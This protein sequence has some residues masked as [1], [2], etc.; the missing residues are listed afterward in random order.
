MPFT[1]SQRAIQAMKTAADV[2]Q[3]KNSILPSLGKMIHYLANRK[4]QNQVVVCNTH[5]ER[6]VHFFGSTT[7]S[8]ID[9]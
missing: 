7:E 1:T 8:T 4:K 6:E 3:E 5:R 2:R 9:N